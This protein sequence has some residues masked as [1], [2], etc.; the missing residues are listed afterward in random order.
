MRCS[1]WLAICSALALL[2]LLQRSPERFTL[3]IAGKCGSSNMDAG[4]SALASKFVGATQRLSLWAMSAKHADSPISRALQK[5]V[6]PGCTPKGCRLFVEF[7]SA[8]SKKTS[9]MYEWKDSNCLIVN[10]DHP[11]VVNK[12]KIKAACKDGSSPACT[13]VAKDYSFKLVAIIFHGLASTYA[14]EGTREHDEAFAWYR[15]M[16]I[17]ELG[18]KLS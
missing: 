1:G 6:D 13:A 12:S 10:M 16:A 14:P 11:S 4:E 3:P 5:Q 17:D 2:L 15:A 7:G 18:W 8:T 9:P